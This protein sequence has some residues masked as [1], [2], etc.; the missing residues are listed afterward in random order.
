MNIVYKITFLDRKENNEPPYYYIGSKSNCVFVDGQILDNKNRPY[1][2][3]SR[4]K[5]YKN[6]V[7][8]SRLLIEVLK[9]FDNYDDAVLY[10]YQL[11][12]DND[13]VKSIEFF[14]LSMASPNS[15]YTKPGYGSYKHKDDY[16]KRIRLPIDDPLVLDG[17]YVGITKGHKLSNETKEKI[18][19]GSTGENNAFFNR[20]HSEETKN[21]ISNANTGRAFSEESRKK[22]SNSRK[23][24]K[25]TEEHKSKIG[26]KGFVMLKHLDTGKSIRIKNEDKHL[27]DSKW[28]NPYTY[29]MMKDPDSVKGK[30]LVNKNTG[31]KIRIN[32]DTKND[33][34][35]SVWI[36]PQ[37][38]T[39]L[40]KGK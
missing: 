20:K 25:K 4:Y 17:T 2:G 18:S 39:K 8:S 14:N 38:Y 32:K 16:N 29:K 35:S 9:T 27:Y 3:S 26:R 36:S 1:F 33:Y 10:E 19:K 30:N 13:V 7:S 24:I 31:E 15:N 21:K 5:N 40:I 6:I 11:Q 23:G 34:D 37:A 12:K 22:M 28:V